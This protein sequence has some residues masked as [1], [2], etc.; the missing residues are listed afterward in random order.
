MRRLL[1]ILLVAGA[2]GCGFERE[3]KEDFESELTD[4]LADSLRAVADASDTGT[5]GPNFAGGDVIGCDGV[6]EVQASAPLCL[7]SYPSQVHVTWSCVGPDG[8]GASGTAD[9][10]TTAVPDACPVSEVDVTQGITLS[11]TWQLDRIA[12]TLTGTADLA[13][14]NVVGQP[15]AQKTVTLALDHRVARRDEVLRHQVVAGTRTIALDLNGV[16]VADDTRVVDGAVGIDFVLADVHAEVTET[17]LTFRRGCC[18]PISGSLVYLLTGETE[19]GG[20]IVFGPTCGAAETGEGRPLDLAPC[21][22][23]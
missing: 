5:I 8:N 18:H 21:V 11:R 15:A 22:V 3:T 1:A 4:S 13:W 23:D 2:S 14:S 17:D 9:V 19:R 16:G 12:A 20:T 6:S 7:A 10:L